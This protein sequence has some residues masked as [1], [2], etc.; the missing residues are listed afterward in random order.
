L[1]VRV[2]VDSEPLSSGVIFVVP[3]NRHV[4][5]SDHHVTVSSGTRRGPKPSVDLLF[6][7]AAK[8]FGE[9]LIA[10]VLSGTG[11]DGAA[12]A[13]VV[14]EAGGSVI[15]Q[16]PS[17][18]AFPGMPRSLAPATIDFPAELDEIGPLLDELAR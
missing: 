12:G 5:I 16:T 8:T 7:S 15:V 13:R 9:R 11:S 6:E 1:P 10:V 18:A 2:V 3:S 17:T 4:E 14:H